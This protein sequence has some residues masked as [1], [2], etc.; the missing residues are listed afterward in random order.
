[1]NYICQVVAQIVNVRMGLKN[2]K[3]LPVTDDNLRNILRGVN[4]SL[5][6]YHNR[7]CALQAKT[8]LANSEVKFLGTRYLNVYRHHCQRSHVGPLEVCKC[9][10][11]LRV[12][13]VVFPC[14]FRIPQQP[15]LAYIKLGLWWQKKLCHLFIAYLFSL[16]NPY[17]VGG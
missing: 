17:A 5:K 16:F 4:V 14:P 8:S 6:H 1:M 12:G 9:F 13:L 15:Q 2:T 7:C 11:W 3:Q 10:H